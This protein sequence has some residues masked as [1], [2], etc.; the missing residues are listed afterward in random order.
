LRIS[1]AD[2]VADGLIERLHGSRARTRV[3]RQ[4]Q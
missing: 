4:L 1:G 2:S 3:R